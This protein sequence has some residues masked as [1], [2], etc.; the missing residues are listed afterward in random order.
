MS[1]DTQRTVVAEDGVVAYRLH[2]TSA[3]WKAWKVSSFMRP[4][5]VGRARLDTYTVSES[6][7]RV[8]YL[9]ALYSNSQSGRWTPA[10][11]YVRLMLQRD[12]TD[13]HANGQ[14]TDEPV[15]EPGDGSWYTMMSDTPD[16]ANDHCEVIDAAWSWGGRVLIHGLGLGCVLNAVLAAPYVE[17][18]D[19]VEVSA[20]VIALVGPYFRRHVEAG[21]LT[22]HHDS[23]VEKSWPVNTRWSIVWHDIWSAISDDNLSLNSE[24]EWGISYATMHRRFA[25]RCMWQGSW[26]FEQARRMRARYARQRRKREQFVFAWNYVWSPERRLLELMEAVS[27]PMMSADNYMRAVATLPAPGSDAELPYGESNPTMLDHYLALT[28]GPITEHGVGMLI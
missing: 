5:R 23:C 17:H 26:G 18:V 27:G 6:N 15:G 8:D 9:R 25:R 24:A 3:Q 10:G 11:D 12:R 13:P 2:L 20:D 14:P 4:G 19:V 22:I 1:I 7:S 28:Q 16:E 21:R